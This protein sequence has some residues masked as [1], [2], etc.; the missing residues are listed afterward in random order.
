MADGEG[1]KSSSGTWMTILATYRMGLVGDTELVVGELNEGLDARDLLVVAALEDWDGPAYL[2]NTDGGV[3][4]ALL[5]PSRTRAP[6]PWVIHAVLLLLTFFTT[7]MAGALLRGIDPLATEF[8]D[9]WGAGIPVPTTV[10]WTQ[11]AV[12]APFALTLMTILMA[13]EMG[14]FLMARRHQVPASLPYFIPFPAYYS[15]IGTL[16][17]FIRIRGPIVRRSVLLDIGVGGPVASFVLSLLFLMVGLSLSEPVGGM[18]GSGMTM[19]VEFAGQPIWL[20]SG[21]A[22]H[23][24]LYLFFPADLGTNVI[25]LH[26]VAFAAWLGLF[27]TFLNLLPFGQLDG[28]HILHAL[29]KRAQRWAGPVCL[30]ALL[31][32]GRLWWG[33]WIWA[34]LAVLLSRGRLAHPK[35]LQPQVGLDPLRTAIAWSAIFIFFL[36]L[37]PLPVRF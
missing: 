3:E 35:V 6:R 20:G 14:H 8:V 29:S 18:V 1:V 4:V 24:I 32:L 33:W 30:L 7:F 12:G 31:P 16:G 17:A 10:N 34:G 19:V 28:G 13:H 21:L 26:P 9:V 22:V 2:T 36:T 37:V 27:V 11:M 25:L 15:A 23:G 5:R